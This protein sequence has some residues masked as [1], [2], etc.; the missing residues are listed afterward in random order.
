ML[1]EQGFNKNIVCH[2]EGFRP[3]FYLKYPDNW[4]NTFIRNSFFGERYLN[5]RNYIYNLVNA[6]LPPKSKEFYG[7]HLDKNNEEKEFKFIKLEFINH[8]YMKKSIK[9]IKHFC[10][11]YYQNI[12]ISDEDVKKNIKEFIDLSKENEEY[13]FDSNL[14][15]SNIHPILRFIHETDI[16]PCGWVEIN[17]EKQVDEEKRRFNVDNEY[18]YLN[19]KY[20]KP[21]DKDEINKFIIAS[22]DIECD[23]SHGD[24]PQACKDTKKL[25]IE[26]FDSF[27]K[28]K[29]HKMFKFEKQSKTW[30]LKMILYAFF[31]L[32]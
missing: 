26:I 5:M 1:N 17:N 14:Y 8:D 13:R 28:L 10:K 16:K 25:A 7:Y 22:F 23:S 2:I 18:K 20:L 11:K 9:I 27:H 32:M 29:D 24:F 12:N 31:L 15:E 21:I 4:S 6:T 19:I 3:Y 30:L